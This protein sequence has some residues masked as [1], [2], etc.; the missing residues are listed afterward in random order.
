AVKNQSLSLTN[1]IVKKAGDIRLPQV[2]Q[3]EFAGIGK[4]ETTVSDVVKSAKDTM[5]KAVGRE[6]GGSAT[7]RR[8]TEEAS[9]SIRGSS[10]AGKSISKEHY[11]ALR[12]K[13][14]SPKIRKKVNPEGPKFDPVYGYEVKKFE[15]DHIVSM[16]EI[17]EMDGFSQLSKEK[18]IEVLNLEDNFVGLGKSTNASK[19]AHSWSDWVGHSKYGEVPENIRQHMLKLEEQARKALRK[20]IEER[21]K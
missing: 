20:A 7:G 18:Q 8:L 19:G 13:T 11:K 12:K 17:T 9:N 5:M 10:G 4:V 1:K 14:P 16:K 21:L 15:A 6:G 2:L 3:P